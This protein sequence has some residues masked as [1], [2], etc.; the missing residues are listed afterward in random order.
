MGSRPQ[1][2]NS[3]ATGGARGSCCRRPWREQIEI[4]V[5]RPHSAATTRAASPDPAEVGERVRVGRL[6]HARGPVVARNSLPCAGVH[7]VPVGDADL[8]A[9]QGVVLDEL[10]IILVAQRPRSGHRPITAR[11]GVLGSDM[12]VRQ[13]T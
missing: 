13:I 5:T 2:L 1:L 7:G 9:E 10:V 6:I 11:R 3:S 8:V 4:I 12:L